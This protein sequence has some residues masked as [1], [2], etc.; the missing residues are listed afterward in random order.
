MRMISKLMGVV[1]AGVLLAGC[2]DVETVIKVKPDGS[3]TVEETM[4]MSK[5]TVEQ[6]KMMTSGM[7]GMF[8]DGEEGQAAPTPEP[9]SLLDEEELKS[10]A[11]E[12][13]EGVTYVSGKELSTEKGEGYVA[14]YAFTDITKLKINK[15]PDSPMGSGM[16]MEMGMAPGME[17]EPDMEPESSVNL[18]PGMEKVTFEFTPGESAVLKLRIPQEESGSEVS[19]TPEDSGEVVLP[20]EGGETD[21]ALD[22]MQQQMMQMFKDMR[23]ALKIVVEGDIQETNA[24]HRDGSAITLFDMHFGK[25]LD[26]M[27]KFEELSKGGGMADFTQAM[28]AM[29]DIEGIKVETQEEVVIKFK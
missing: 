3:G 10:K 15:E 4:I 25:L 11:K 24:S 16:G 26:D 14:V 6:M 12:M 13:G 28:E 21:E 22:P 9:F 18:A 7:A 27:S 2:M 23:F 29:K 20:E 1:L 5:E 17:M 8:T 19:E